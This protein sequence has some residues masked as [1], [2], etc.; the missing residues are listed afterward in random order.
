[1]SFSV[2]TRSP[3]RGGCG[4]RKLIV[5]AC[6][7]RRFD[8]LH[9]I[10]LLELALRLRRFARFGAEA[11]GES[12]GARRFPA[13]GSCRRRA[14]ALRAPLSVRCSCPSC[15]GNA[16]ALPARSRR[17]CRRAG[18]GTRGRA[19][20]SGSRRDSLFRYSWNQTS[21]SRSR[22]LVGSSSKQK[23]GSCTSKPREMRAHD[24]AAAHA[25]A[26]RSKSLSRK[27]RPRRMC[28][29]FG[30]SCQ[31]P[32]SSKTWSASDAL[33]EPFR[34]VSFDQLLHLASSGEVAIASSSTVSSPAA[35]VSWGRNPIVALFSIETGLQ[36]GD[37][38]PRISEK[39]VD[40]PAPFGPTSPMRSPRFTWSETSSKRTR[41]AKD[42]VTCET[43]SIEFSRMTSR[44]RKCWSLSSQ[45]LRECRRRGSNPHTLASTGF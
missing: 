45:L 44:S 29:A 28:F 32:C 34:I 6:A 15:R 18:S 20:S 4:K 41:P 8:L 33:A 35:A 13:A 23:S 25:L 19:R 17:C 31:P 27:A 3:L 7:V 26:G 14:A 10:D 36:S 21:A 24:P 12:S 39:S 1:M 5:F 40:L 16:R 22:W 43:V 11:V 30:S 9:P 38:S 42:L 2:I 37:A